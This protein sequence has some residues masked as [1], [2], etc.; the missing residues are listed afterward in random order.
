MAFTAPQK[1]TL[2]M[3][4]RTTTT[5]LSAHL[6][7]LGATLTADKQTA[8]EA[9]MARWTSAG[10]KFTKLHPRE[11]NKGVETF[12]EAVK[13]DIRQNIAALLEWPISSGS[14]GTLQIG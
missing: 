1:E 8:V 5:L 11:A 7:S 13:A 6:T 12:P 3:T 9:Q 4:L 14:M 2:A 10:S